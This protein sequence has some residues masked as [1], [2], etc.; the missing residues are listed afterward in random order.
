[1]HVF[2]TE[3]CFLTKVSDPTTAGT[4][5]VTGA[6]VDMAAH[7]GFEGVCFF[8][9]F[10]T[11]AAGNFLKAQ[12]SSDDGVADG[13]S[14]LEGSAVDPGASDEDQFVDIVRPLKRYLRPVAIRGTSSALGD[15]WALLYRGSTIPVVNVIAGTINGVKLLSPAE[16]T[17]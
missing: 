17:A 7:G 3:S 15:V 6:S 8:S 10:G 14:D 9:S 5:D 1:M 13:F 16:G 11:A 2:L 4:S 12:Q